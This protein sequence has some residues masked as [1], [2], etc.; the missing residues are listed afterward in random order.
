MEKQILENNE[1][2]TCLAVCQRVYSLLQ[3]ASA[4]LEKCIGKLESQ[5]NLTFWE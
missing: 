5:S 4:E 2:T 3:M 1:A